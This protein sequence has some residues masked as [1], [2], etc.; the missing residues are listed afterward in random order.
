MAALRLRHLARRCRTGTSRV[1]HGLP[2]GGSR[3]RSRSRTRLTQPLCKF[4][5]RHLGETTRYEP[6]SDTSHKGLD[7]ALLAHQAWTMARAHRLLGPA[8]LGQG[9][10]TL[11][12][13]LTSDLVFDEAERVWI[14]SDGGTSISEAS[15]VLL[16]LL[17]TGDD[18]TTAA[19]LATSLWSS[20]GAQGRFSCDMDPAFDEDAFQDVTRDRRCWRSRGGGEE[21]VRSG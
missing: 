14:R 1:E 21:G 8:P 5:L 2:R 4:L 20:I 18:N 6:F 11:L 13:A 15:F 3:R 7:T 17:E 16:A 12:S 19:T 9:A 10:R